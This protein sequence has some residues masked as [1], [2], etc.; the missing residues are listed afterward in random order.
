MYLNRLKYEEKCSFLELAK[1]I[2]EVDG[3]TSS[4]EI[5]VIQQYI[6]EV[7]FHQNW[8]ILSKSLDEI[9]ESF[10]KSSFLVK[11]IILFE[12]LILVH[13]D[14]EFCEREEKVIRRLTDSFSIPQEDYDQLVDITNNL[15]LNLKQVNG[16]LF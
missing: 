6:K 2:S 14:N 16:I 7:G 11:K 4:E 9:L 15:V 8:E 10:N 1:C 13:S 5:L 3:N 12:I